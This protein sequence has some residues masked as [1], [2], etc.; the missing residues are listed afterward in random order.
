MSKYND[1]VYFFVIKVFRFFSFIF[2]MVMFES[3]LKISFEVLFKY[4]KIC[5]I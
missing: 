1:I 3:F 5:I 2:K 4:D